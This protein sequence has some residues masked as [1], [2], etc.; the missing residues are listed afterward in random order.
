MDSML[1]GNKTL[2]AIELGYSKYP[3]KF[4]LRFWIQD[5]PMGA[6]KKP[7][8]LK[9][10][11]DTFQKILKKKEYMFLPVFNGMSATEI[12][13]YTK[14]NHEIEE[15]IQRLDELV[16]LYKLAF[17]GKQF[18][19][20][21]SAYLILYKDSFFHFIWKND[22]D[23]PLFEAKV[24]LDEFCRVFNDYAEYCYREGLI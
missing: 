23:K 15:D 16:P 7:G 21:Q 19:D 3:N 13:N 18:T 20:T 24:R 12:H 2:F 6:F 5:L 9:F 22:F 17:F 4:Y 10:S 1:F 11:V 8:D 14:I